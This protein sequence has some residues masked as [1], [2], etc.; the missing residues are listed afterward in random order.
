M[1]GRGE[2]GSGGE[3]AGCL[4]DSL[5]VWRAK[6]NRPI[7]YGRLAELTQRKGKRGEMRDTTG[8]QTRDL[9]PIYH[10]IYR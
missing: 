10:S 7:D 3:H 9:V 5:S 4:L 1:Q 6:K 8:Y 2:E